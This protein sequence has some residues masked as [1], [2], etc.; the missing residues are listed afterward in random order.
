[1]SVPT[2]HARL[3]ARHW[4]P[5]RRGGAPSQ[6]NVMPRDDVARLGRGQRCLAGTALVL[7]LAGIAYGTTL[8]LLRASAALDLKGLATPA[9]HQRG[10]VL[11]LASTAALAGASFC[12]GHLW[13][14]I[15]GRLELLI[16]AAGAIGLPI[17]AVLVV[18]SFN[19]PLWWPD[20]LDTDFLAAAAVLSAG[21]LAL[22]APAAG[23]ARLLT[24]ACLCAWG[25]LLLGAG[26][27][28]ILFLE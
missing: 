21:M 25:V 9:Q 23:S 3:D 5:L 17:G 15:I 20:W 22:F 6:P 26:T 8:A 2:S 4:V 7:L 10:M 13:R 11:F 16:P 24:S 28:A 18:L 27:W 19:Y 1:M 12:L 14:R